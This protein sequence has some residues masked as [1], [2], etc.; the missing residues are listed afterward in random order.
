MPRRQSLWQVLH[1]IALAALALVACRFSWHETLASFAD[2]APNYLLMAQ[3]W[4]PFVAA[5]E[6][7]REGCAAERYP[8]L[9]PLLLALTGTAHS[10]LAAHQLVALTFVAAVA[11][12]Y[13]LA[14]TILE[15]RP[16]ASAVAL[17]MAV[18]PLA[19]TNLL[20]ILS[21]NLYL[22]FS[23]TAL[24]ALL[25]QRAAPSNGR[26]VTAGLLLAAALLTRSVGISL[27]AAAWAPPALARLGGRPVPR[28]H[29]LPGLL[30]LLPL[31]LWHL[32]SPAQ[33][34]HPYALEVEAMLHKLL[35]TPEI[36]SLAGGFLADRGQLFTETW[37]HSLLNFWREDEPRYVLV[38]LFGGMA[39]L[40]WLR[41]LLGNHPDGWAVLFQLAILLVWPYPSQMARFFYAFFPILLIHAVGGALWLGGILAYRLAAGPA[42]RRGS[43]WAALVALLLAMLPAQW[44]LVQRTRFITPYPGY[45]LTRQNSF[46]RFATLEEAIPFAL[47]RDHLLHLMEKVRQTTPP[48]ERIL[49]VSPTYLFLLAERRGVGL[50]KMEPG[51]DLYR[52]VEHS[53]A[54]LLLLTRIHPRN[55]LVNGGLHLRA[56]FEPVSTLVWESLAVDGSGLEA[57]LLRLDRARLA[58]ARITVPTP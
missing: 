52:R 31:G 36:L 58:Q 42:V 28:Q 48:Q 55:P 21:E 39:L 15:S 37:L 18:S 32:V 19:W 54:E 23:L 14:E 20:G 46:Y 38:L 56:V 26:A 45:D 13:R 9:F 34:H 30:A 17:L 47:A 51:E 41:R 6:I 11:A 4:S 27:L 7:I 24:I 1:W 57:V 44:T 25:N 16:A 22:L 35:Q 53:G 8:P 5:P 12:C 49:W 3:C 40:G 43:A 10:L 50:P 2:D 33:P 29:W